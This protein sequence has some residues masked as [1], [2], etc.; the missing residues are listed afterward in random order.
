MLTW[1]V[2]AAIFIATFAAIVVSAKRSIP[3]G[4]RYMRKHPYDTS[5]WTRRNGGRAG[6]FFDTQD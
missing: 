2:L 6:R 3:G 1:L 5:R 4:R